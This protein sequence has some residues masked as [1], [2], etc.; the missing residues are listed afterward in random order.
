MSGLGTSID[1]VQVT[2]HRV[3]LPSTLADATQ[4]I[5]HFEYV[6]VELDAVGIRGSGYAYTTGFGGAAIAD[7]VRTQLIDLVLG[8][9]V[10]AIRQAWARG[11]AALDRGGYG[12]LSALALAA[13]DIARWDLAARAVGEPLYAFLGGVGRSCPTYGSGVDLADGPVAL[14]ERAAAMLDAGFHGVKMKL[15]RDHHAN[16]A[17]L[18][19]V[20]NRIGPDIPLFVDA[21]TAWTI[22]DVRLTMSDLVRAEVAFLEEPLPIEDLD[23]YRSLVGASPVPLAGG[24]TAHSA[25]TLLPYISE[26]ILGV[27]QPDICRIGGITEWLRI[28][29]AAEIARIPITTHFTIELAAHLAGAVPTIQYVEI[30]DHNLTHLGLVEGGAVI[31][32]GTITPLDEP[33]H[34]LRW[35]MPPRSIVSTTTHSAE[36]KERT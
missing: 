7:L 33:G 23:G 34:G 27:I 4:T 17:R 12:N 6:V 9:P 21:N 16:R 15:G 8:Q 28:A 29:A 30:T 24:E 14:G 20:R 32:H 36:T 25:S 13:V 19:A 22:Q 18:K 11:R 31:G 1:R 3:R 5:D 2:H 26:R 35:L 10:G